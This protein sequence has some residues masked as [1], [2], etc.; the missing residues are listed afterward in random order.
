MVVAPPH[1]L[2][3]DVIESVCVD[4]AGWDTHREWEATRWDAPPDALVAIWSADGSDNCRV[5]HW[6]DTLHQ[7]DVTDGGL[8]TLW[9]RE[10]WDLVNIPDVPQNP[11]G[12][13]DG[14]GERQGE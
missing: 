5:L 11:V 8:M 4:T 13:I 3:Q 9:Q 1:A 7:A 2:V 10:E 14:V 6:E 12:N